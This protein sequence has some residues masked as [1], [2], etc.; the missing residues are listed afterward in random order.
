[1]VNENLKNK[2]WELVDVPTQTEKMFH[3]KEH[4]KTLDLHEAILS[5]LNDVHDLKLSIGN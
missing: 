3:D 5:I 2:T 4:N 1:M